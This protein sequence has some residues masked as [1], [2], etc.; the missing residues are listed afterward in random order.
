MALTRKFL[1]DL[2]V[3]KEQIQ[4]ILDEHGET[5]E[6]VKEKA[7][8]AADLAAGKLQKKIDKLQET[9]DNIP[10]PDGED[11]K[12]KYETEVTAHG[13]TKKTMQQT[14]D[15]FVAGVNTKETTAAKRDVLRKQLLADGANPKLLDLLEK[16]FDLDKIEIDG[17]SVKDWDN[18]SAPVKKS[19][20]DVFTEAGVQGTDTKKP[21]EGG[22][23]A[24]TTEQIKSMTP[25]EINA[26]WDAVKTTL[27]KKG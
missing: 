4:S 13:E 12:F 27:S 5:V 24:Y 9:V 7:K 3:E 11:Y 16:G 15:D 22:G 26:N 14:Y 6:S 21:P 19:Y 20:A 18:V 25:Q 2:G 23:K 10:E 8:E 17:E 1:I